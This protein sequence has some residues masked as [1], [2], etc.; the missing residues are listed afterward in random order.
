MEQ[1]NTLVNGVLVLFTSKP[2]VT[3][4]QVMKV[5]PAEIRA[6]VRLYL[7]GT[8]RQWFSRG[9]GKGVVLIL[10]SK[11]AAEARAAIDGLPLSAE[12]L[13]D[14]EFIPIGP[15]MFLGGLL[16]GAPQQK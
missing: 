11:D 2:G 13:M 7:N 15:L 14:H 16:D 4:E 10:N 6:T 8:I 9:D 1:P 12:N 5:M 3:R